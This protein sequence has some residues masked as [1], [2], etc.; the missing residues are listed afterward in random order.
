M[1]VVFVFVQI[2]YG[3]FLSYL[4]LK[5]REGVFSLVMCIFL[6]LFCMKLMEEKDYMEIVCWILKVGVQNKVYFFFEWFI[7]NKLVNELRVFIILIYILYLY[8]YLKLKSLYFV[9]II[10]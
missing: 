7:N 8:M 9:L 4:S 10:L 1:V 2:C 3:W 6:L 5:K